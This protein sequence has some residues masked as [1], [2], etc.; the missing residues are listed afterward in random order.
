MQDF[1]TKLGIEENN[2]GGFC[3]EWLGS[4]PQLEVTSP[5]DGGLIDRENGILN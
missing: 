2:P 1:L 3:G 5:I 4:G